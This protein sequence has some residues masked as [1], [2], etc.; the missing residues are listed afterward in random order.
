MDELLIQQGI[1]LIK[2]NILDVVCEGAK[3][4]ANH[5]KNEIIP[6]IVEY[7]KRVSAKTK[8]Q[9]VGRNFEVLNKEQ[10]IEVAKS[11]KAQEADGIAAY[12]LDAPDA[13]FIYL[14][15]VKDRI[16]LPEEHNKYAIIRATAISS[17]VLKLFGTENLIILK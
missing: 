6:Q 7:F 1:E 4:F 8:A 14:A 11:I 16:L 3:D 17:D 10:L 5:V 2:E 12:R 13:A 9:I 15:N